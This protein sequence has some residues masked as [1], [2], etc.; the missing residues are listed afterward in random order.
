M[1]VSANEHPFRR[2]ALDH[3]WSVP[4]GAFGAAS[5]EINNFQIYNPV[6]AIGKMVD[7]ASSGHL[8]TGYR[9]KIIE[10]PPDDL[11]PNFEMCHAQD[12]SRKA[13]IY[14]GPEICSALVK[15]QVW[16]CSRQN[17]KFFRVLHPAEI[18]K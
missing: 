4:L 6:I 2:R 14:Y 7:G 10:R 8:Q 17:N 18:S 9:P 11:P 15:K 13:N 1:Q 12:T 3:N 5:V 16:R